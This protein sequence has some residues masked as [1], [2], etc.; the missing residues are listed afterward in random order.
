[1]DCKNL[2]L[3]FLSEQIKGLEEDN[4]KLKERIGFLEK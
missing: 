1:M 2:H 4:I 3:R